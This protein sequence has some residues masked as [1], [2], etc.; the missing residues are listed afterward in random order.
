MTSQEVKRKLAAI[1]SADV[2]G[3]SR[4]MGEDEVQTLKTL[5]AYFQI[6]TTLIQ[7]HQGKILN[8]AGDNLLADFESVVDAVQC[9]VEIQKE[10]RTKNAELA[11]SQRV[12]FRIGIN[13]GDVIREGESIYGDGVNIAARLESL[14]EA[15]GVCISG[16]AYDQVENKLP[17]G[18]QYLGEQAV[19]NIA[20]PVR[21]YKVL[22]EPEP[23][24]KVVGEKKIKPKQWQRTA[25]GLVVA[26]IVIVAAVV[27][28][29]LLMPPAPQR[30][31]A[32]KE[33]MAFP[34][35]D[36]PSIAV[37]PFDNMSGDRE[38]D[39]LA[40]GITENIISYLSK[41]AEMFVID[42][43]STSIYKG[44]PVKVQQVSEDL[45]VRY[46]LEGSVQK[47]G[48]KLRVTAQLVDALKGHPLWSERYDRDFQDLFALQDEITLNI[49]KAM[50][51]QLTRGEIGRRH[52]TTSIEAWSYAV[53]GLSLAEQVKKEAVL[54][55]RSLYEKALK[56]DPSYGYVWDLLAW[57]YI[58]EAWVGWT[59]SPADSLR[60]ALELAQKAEATGKVGANF[61]TTMEMIYMLQGKYDEAIAEG[62]KA[63]TFEPNA[64]GH[65]IWLARVLRYSGR[66]N[67]AIANVK[68]AMRLHPYYPAYYLLDL[69]GAY[70][71]GGQYS[72]AIAAGNK[73]LERSLKGE[74]FPLYAHEWLAITYGR[75]G[76]IEKARAHADEILKINPKYTVESFRKSTPYKDRAYLD[77]LVNLLIKAGLPE[78]PPTTSPGL[79]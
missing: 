23:A 47:S 40:D 12:E 46:I 16:T 17:L 62:E 45:G 15:G 33:K 53:K 63:I 4:L 44:K 69:T 41:I 20:K 14:S 35:P 77:G 31:V 57:T 30:E 24:G 54:E 9:G 38:Q 6:M 66:P 76:Q 71:M 28:W 75:L 34:L 50:Q 5:S 32:S 22:M 21:V 3:Y 64:A 56:L 74:F 10:L 61:H 59:D 68:K 42:R 8:I 78:N 25:I 72:E 73:L 26:V 19:K 2:K 48:N 67:E 18:Y 70:D 11:E 55:A 79:K 7:K 52:D 1:L 51:V 29:R 65:Y 27:I 37:L 39:Y 36:K 43:K 58:L 49:L 13:L 60:R